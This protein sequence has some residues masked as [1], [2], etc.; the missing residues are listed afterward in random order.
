VRW[1]RKLPKGEAC[2]GLGLRASGLNLRGRRLALWNADPQ[3]AYERDADPLYTSIPFYMGVRNDVAF[4]VL[5]DNPA[6][7][8]VDL[9]ATSPGQMVFAAEEG[10]G[11]FA[12][13]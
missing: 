9:G 7:G 3:P 11:N 2:Y 6:R 13:T 10:E 1:S 4:G 12:S 5:W 8:A